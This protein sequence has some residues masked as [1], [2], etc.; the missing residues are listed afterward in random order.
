MLKFYIGL[1]LSK[2]EYGRD[3]RIQAGRREQKRGGTYQDNALLPGQPVAEQ[4][5]PA[6][7]PFQNSRFPSHRSALLISLFSSMVNC[8]MMNPLGLSSERPVF[9]SEQEVTRLRSVTLL[10]RIISCLA[11]VRIL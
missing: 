7:H 10:S 6:V 1:P 4:P 2:M 8:S 9:W 5:Y 11:Y 3:D